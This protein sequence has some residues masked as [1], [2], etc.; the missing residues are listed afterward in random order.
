VRFVSLAP[1]FVALFL[2]GAA[3]AQSWE[4]FTNQENFFSANFP[5]TPAQSQT[6]YTTLKGKKLPAHVF[7][8]TVPPGSRLS[9]TY[10]ITVVDFSTAKDEMTSATEHA[11]DAVRAKGTIKYDAVENLD[12]HATRRLTVETA[13]N[14]RV[15]AEI[16]YAENNRLY[17]S[18][19]EISKNL[20]PPAQFQASL[21][22]LDDK[23]QRI[24]ERTLLGLPEGTK[25]P[26]ATG[27]IADEPE[28]VA[29]LMRGSWRTP[30]GS[31]TAPYFKSG[32]RSKNSRG[33][34]VMMGTVVNG[35]TTVNGML[36]VDNSR[37]G[38]FVDPISFQI[39]MLFDPM[40]DGKLGISALGGPA[41]GWPDVTLEKCTG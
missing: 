11:A 16:L 35:T 18:Q 39:L 10:T 20:P 8:V 29:A 32:A 22:V 31:C 36:I 28:K 3:C 21:Q 1:A 27:G 7:T 15:L 5:G 34:E 30:G 4:T 17:I 23:G 24:R 37:A 13:A 38:Q 2:S 12:L 33:E 6:T 26:I 9:G 40:D 19:A 25:Q 41:A 14:T